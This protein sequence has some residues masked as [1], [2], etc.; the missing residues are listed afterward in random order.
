MS[1][2]DAILAKDWPHTPVYIGYYFSIEPS[3]TRR[4]VFCLDAKEGVDVA[5]PHP[6]LFEFV[7]YFPPRARCLDCRNWVIPDLSAGYAECAY[8]GAT[9]TLRDLI[10]RAATRLMAAAPNGATLYHRRKR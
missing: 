4:A 6:D 9:W 1:K 7:R 2:N 5:R 10:D 3:G 8:C